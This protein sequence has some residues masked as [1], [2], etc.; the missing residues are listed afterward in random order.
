M[1]LLSSAGASQR[2]AEFIETKLD[3]GIIDYSNDELSMELKKVFR[4]GKKNNIVDTKEDLEYIKEQIF[5]EMADA[6]IIIPENFQEKVI[7]KENAIEIYNDE[8]KIGS[9]G[10]QNQINKFLLFANAT[11]ENGKYNLADVDLALKENIN[12]KLIDNNT[13]KNISINEWFRNYFNFTSYVIIGMYI[14]IIGLVMADFTDENIEKK[15]RKYPQ[16]N[17]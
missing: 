1:S 3:I 17:F 7:N 15:G 9:M 10:I 6:I 2:E 13:A 8:R 12:V 16:R 11:Y 4:G 14:S 5:L